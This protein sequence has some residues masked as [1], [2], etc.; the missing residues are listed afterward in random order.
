MRARLPAYDAAVT[1]TTTAAQQES[2]P[3]QEAATRRFRLGA[4]RAF[5][6][7]PGGRRVA[8][9]RSAGGRDPVGS[10]WV[11]EAG[12]D[13]TLTE[14]CV[15]D[16]R[17]LHD[18]AADLPAAERA[19]RERMRETTSGITGFSAD[20]QVTRAVFAVDGELYLA[21]LVDPAAAAVPLAHPGPV[22]DPRLSPDGATVAFVVDGALWVVAT[23]AD[24]AA[25]LLAE[26]PDAT[27]T[28]GLAD[29]VA[30]EE[31]DRSRGLWWLTDSAAVLAELV[32]EAPVEVRW[33]GD[34]ARPE[35]E[36]AA[37]RYPMAG[38]ANPVA[39]LFRIGLDGSR[40]EV[41]WDRDAFCYLATVH[42]G[43]DGTTVVSVLS[44]DQRR[45][46]ILDVGPDGTVTIARERTC[47]PWL[48]MVSGVPCRTPD[49]RLLEVV[50]DPE[51]DTFRLVADDLPL[52]PAGLQVTGV[53][54]ATAE[55][56][57]V[58]AQ[59][60]PFDQHVYGV[61]GEVRQV[62]EGPGIH[63]AAAGVGGVVVASARPDGLGTEY[64]ATLAAA[65]GA[66]PSRAELPVVAPRPSFARVGDR[67]LATAVLWPTGHVP[68][69]RRLP[70]VLA[71]YGGPHH[72]RVVHAAGAFA[73]DQWLADQGFAVVVV[74]GAGTPGRG[75]AFEF[76][77]SGDLATTVL[78]D[79]VDALHALAAE[80]PDLDLSRVGITGWSFG[81]FLA[82]LA[83]LDRPDVFAVA[84][85]GAPVTDWALY[86][87]AYSERYL[88]LPQ[89]AP[90]AYRASSLIERAARLERPLLLVHGLA[91]DNVLAA[92]TLQLS[93]ALLAAGRPHSV[94]PLSGVTHMTPQE[95]VAEN[96]LRLQVAFLHEH[97]RP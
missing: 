43:A 46:A 34:P 97:L 88:G 17:D 39:R 95:V 61:A 92:H 55:R 62:S 10:L 86:D 80:H 2:Y 18:P 12:A 47:S 60:D 96:L 83:V 9:V 75:P 37:H 32:D 89:E 81:G 8:F 79:Q 58:T 69:S 85:A 23:D 90:Q 20:E 38:T 78:A 54:C 28:W 30:A 41:E 35:R 70:V 91:D 42:P 36:P 7:A 50:A 49:G 87:T 66:I 25:R 44:R 84:V 74:D 68:G 6:V 76:E 71:P 82:A 77:V 33:I 48:T 53:V 14:R 73:A 31:L 51:T 29:F 64:V 27:S 16:A 56:L 72:A 57:V 26:P 52:T 21:N 15:V 59:P 24:A 40:R 45:Q 65:R 94:L 5:V 19:R 67:E 4:P 22:V 63:A 11:A 3:R 1:S 93:G 13:G